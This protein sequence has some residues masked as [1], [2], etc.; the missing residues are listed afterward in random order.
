MTFKTTLAA[1][2][3]ALS[4]VGLGATSGTA[5]AGPQADVVVRIGTPGV[6]AV[7]PGYRPARHYRKAPRYRRLPSR[8]RRPARLRRHRSCSPVYAKRR[9]FVRGY[10]WQR[11][12]VRVGR[13][14]K[15]V[16]R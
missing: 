12:R 5:A 6:V 1:A 9:V 7:M 16:W 10:G 4:L 8:Y 2:A 14:C 13:T 11:A 15:T 3:V